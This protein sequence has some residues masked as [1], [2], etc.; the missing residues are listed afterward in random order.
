MDEARHAEY[1]DRLRAR[2]RE[3]AAAEARMEETARAAPEPDAGDVGDRAADTYDKERTL[4]E[5]DQDRRWLALIRD[6]LRREAEGT[7]GLCV[8]C[9]EP[10]EDKR[11]NAVPWARHCLRCQELQDKGLL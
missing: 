7:Y 6:A 11:L 1:I 2:E 9:G 3:L 8:A 10:I 5:L 4:R